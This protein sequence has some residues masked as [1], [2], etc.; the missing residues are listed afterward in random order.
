MSLA[1]RSRLRC[2]KFL[3]QVRGINKLLNTPLFIL[4]TAKGLL[5]MTMPKEKEIIDTTGT[6]KNLMSLSA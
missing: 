4:L 1:T 5:V 6:K 3:N 2:E